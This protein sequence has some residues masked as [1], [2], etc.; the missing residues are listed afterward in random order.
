MSVYTWDPSL[1]TSLNG[2]QARSASA[3]PYAPGRI[4]GPAEMALPGMAERVRGA[5]QNDPTSAQAVASQAAREAGLGGVG[6]GPA[7]AVAQAGQA[8]AGGRDALAAMATPGTIRTAFGDLTPEQ[9]DELALQGAERAAAMEAEAN[10]RQALE[11]IRAMENPFSEANMQRAQDASLL[12]LRV[13]QLGQD[14][15][16]YTDAAARGMGSAGGTANRAAALEG[17]Q[18]AEAARR[19]ADLY[20]RFTQGRGEFEARRATQEAAIL[21]NNQPQALAMDALQRMRGDAR[22]AQGQ[23]LE[24]ANM[25]DAIARDNLKNILGGVATVGGTLL[26]GPAGGAVAN[27]GAQALSALFGAFSPPTK[28]NAGQGGSNKYR[29]QQMGPTQGGTP[30]GS[31]WGTATQAQTPSQS[32][33]GIGGSNTKPGGYRVGWGGK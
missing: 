8:L 13:S 32:M 4:L 11:A 24:Q 21:Q 23:S 25:E 5:M 9:I 22:F 3:L 20:D 17:A 10:R 2:G 7:T 31:P 26:A 27:A 18:Q 12:G 28:Q 6:G 14:R 15:S 1:F 29:D 33:S 30:L 19:T 16:I